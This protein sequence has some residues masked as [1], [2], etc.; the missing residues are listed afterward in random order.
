MGLV[1]SL[2]IARSYGVEERHVAAFAMVTSS[3]AVAHVRTGRTDADVKFW[4]EVGSVT[5]LGVIVYVAI[6]FV[7]LPAAELVLLMFL[8]ARIVPQLS[9][10]HQSFQALCNL[11]PAILSVR[12]LAAQCSAAAGPLVTN[13]EAVQMRQAVSF[14]GISFGYPGVT[15]VQQL[16]LTIRAGETTALVGRSGAGK[17]TV[18]DLLMGLLTPEH[19]RLVVD[20]VR[21]T[22][23]RM[24]AWRT[25][26]GYVAQET[27][28][29]HDTVR[30]NL[31]WAEPSATE[32]DIWEA[33]RLAAADQFVSRLPHV[34]D[35]VLGDRGVLVSAGERQRL[36]L[37]RALLRKPVL[38]ILDEATSSLDSE[39]EQRIQRAINELRGRMTMLII[40]HR[41]STIRDADVIHLLDEGRIAESG[42]W[43]ALVMREHGRFQE[44]YRAQEIW[45]PSL[46]DD[47]RAVGVDLP[48]RSGHAARAIG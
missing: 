43:D 3:V 5:I 6:S 1:A 9:N 4:F 19:G 20:G 48:R 36:A 45:S 28:L 10:L 38:L 39:N 46:D 17:S 21:L 25:Q 22:P 37:A 44:L 32:R 40:A 27:F 2:K 33:L 12:D 34:L 31:L 16:D 7:A 26:I 13:G 41:L 8:F 15:V 23:D 14:E 47:R 35:T 42:S 11:M 24:Q 30:A 29:F 18:A